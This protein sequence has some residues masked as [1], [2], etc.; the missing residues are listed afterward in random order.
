VTELQLAIVDERTGSLLV[1]TE[2]ADIALAITSDLSETLDQP[3]E[4]GCARPRQ[5]IHPKPGDLSGPTIRING[6]WHDSLVE[7][8][9]RRSVVRMQGCPIRCR[10]CWVPETHAEDGGYL[11]NVENL[12]D[13]LMD[14]AFERDGVT[15]L[16]G[17]P[18]AQPTALAEL[19]ERLRRRGCRDITVYTGYTLETLHRKV[20]YGD[21]AAASI[22]Y[23]LSTIDRLIDGP[24]VAALASGAGAWTG[25]GNQRVLDLK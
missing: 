16:G 24:Y 10:G 4:M 11:V 2:N 14:E 6:M 15:I 21:A 8:P 1:D 25:S 18:F 5:I 7:G 19:V 17:E 23:V 12:T 20:G 3:N 13:A 9:G 22:H